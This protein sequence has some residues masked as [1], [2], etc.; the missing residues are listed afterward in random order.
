MASNSTQTEVLNRL[1]N[2]KGHIAGIERMVEEGQQCSSVLIQLS[3]IRASIEKIGI[4]ILEN[5][6]IECLGDITHNPEDKQKVEQIVKQ[7]ISFLK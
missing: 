1:K 2:V 7:M 6:A 3:A 4:Y 5:N